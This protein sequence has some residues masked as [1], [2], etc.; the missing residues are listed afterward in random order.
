MIDD[1]AARK[2][3]NWKASTSVPRY[4]GKGYTHDENMEKGRKS[5]LFST[6]LPASGEYE[7]RLAYSTGTNRAT[8]T[9][10]VVEFAGGKK[11][12]RVNQ[13]RAPT[14]EGL[15]V[16]L[17]RYR[18]EKSELA[19][20]TIQT[21]GTDGVVIADAVQFVPAALVD[22]P[23][24]DRKDK[25]DGRDRKDKRHHVEAATPDAHRDREGQSRS[26]RSSNRRV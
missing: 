10:V 9:P 13:R 17:G 15:L 3:G 12:V 8:N 20:V 1:T 25:Q 4:V 7:V 22:R 2:I 5:V 11:T 24:K 21:V 26:T 14:I 6:G 23:T 16:S 19:K 18:F